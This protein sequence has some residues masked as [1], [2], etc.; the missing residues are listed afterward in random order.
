MNKKQSPTDHHDVAPP[1]TIPKTTV[2]S[3]ITPDL[4]AVLAG[5]STQSATLPTCHME[6]KEDA[7]GVWKWNEQAPLASPR[8]PVRLEVHTTSYKWLNLP[9][10]QP[11]QGSIDTLKG[12]AVP[13]TGAQMDVCGIN[14][15]HRMGVDITSLFPVAARVFGASRDRGK[16]KS[17]SRCFCLYYKL[18]KS[19]P[20]VVY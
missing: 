18:P 7:R 19:D 14:L 20:S 10:P 3:N 1:C 6:F 4:S 8:L 2:A 12:Q 13:D 17:L 15:M 16:E 5:L 9:P 11:M